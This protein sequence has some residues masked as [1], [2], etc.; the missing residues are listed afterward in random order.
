L[1][2][3]L[4]VFLL[5]VPLAAPTWAG[6]PYLTDDPEPVPYHHWEVYSFYTRDQ[7]RMSDTVNGPALELNN[8]IAPNTQIH[9][10]IPD[11]YFSSGGTSAH[12]LGDIELGVKYRF[13]GQTSSR[14][15]I[16]TFPQIELPTGDSSQGLGNGRTWVKLPVWLQKDWGA[17]TAYGGAGY[18]Y[19]SAP[20][21]RNYFFG[22]LLAQYT[23]SPRLT[24]GGDIFLQGA[25]ANAPEAISAGSLGTSASGIPVAGTRSSEIWEVG[26]QYN[27][28]P[29][30][31]LL[32]S[33]GH[34]FQ[35]DGNRVVYL[36][37]Y[38]TFGPGS[39]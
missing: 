11:T 19:N 28:T 34:S 29:D 17:F 1:K 2:A 21:Q 39:P 37:L 13:L 23:L 22:G 8:G 26:G 7:T 18:A 31:S 15:D 33:T 4:F 12:G 16:G 5:L 20:G 25:S 38:R 6:P 27:F 32:F 35:G 30:F 24:L 10:I 3:I 9:L 14:P 36:G